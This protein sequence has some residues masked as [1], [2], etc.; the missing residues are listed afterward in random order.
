M[1][2]RAIDLGNILSVMHEVPQPAPF[3]GFY[4]LRDREAVE[5]FITAVNTQIS[6]RY[7][8]SDKD[9][10]NF[11]GCCLEGEASR[12]FRESRGCFVDY[13]YDEV[14]SDF[15]REF[16]AS[17]EDASMDSISDVEDDAEDDS[18]D[19]EDRLYRLYQIGSVLSYVG[20]F[21]SLLCKLPID[22]QNMVGPG[23]FLTGLKPKV[24]HIVKKGGSK[25]L[26]DMIRDALYAD[27]GKPVESVKRGNPASELAKSAKIQKRVADSGT[28]RFLSSQEPLPVLNA[29]NLAA[30]STSPA[31]LTSSEPA[32][33]IAPAGS[34]NHT[35]TT[36]SAVP[37]EPLLRSPATISTVPLEP[38]THSP[39]TVS[40]A[41][42]V[43]L[44]HSL[45]T[46]SS[47]AALTEF[48]TV[49][50][51]PIGQHAGPTVASLNTMSEVRIPTAPR[52]TAGAASKAPASAPKGSKLSH[53]KAPVVRVLTG[54]G[55]NAQVKATVPPTGPA[56]WSASGASGPFTK[57]TTIINSNINTQPAGGQQTFTAAA[58]AAASTPPSTSQGA[59]VPQQTASTPK[60]ADQE[61][62][63]VTT[64]SPATQLTTQ[65][66]AVAHSRTNSAAP[67]T[68]T[69]QTLA[70]RLAPIDAPSTATTTTN[71]TNSAAPMTPTQPATDYG[72]TNNSTAN[73]TTATVNNTNAAAA[74]A[75]AAVAK[76][77]SAGQS[78]SATSTHAGLVAAAAAVANAP[79]KTPAN[80]E[81][82]E[83]TG[84]V[85][86]LRSRQ[87]SV[88]PP[89]KR[90][91]RHWSPP[92]R[93]SPPPRW[94]PP[95]QTRQAPSFSERLRPRPSPTVAAGTSTRQTG[96]SLAKHLGGGNVSQDNGG[97]VDSG[98]FYCRLSENQDDTCPYHKAKVV[99]KAPARFP[100]GKGRA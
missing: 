18:L 77:P 65:T 75:A 49:A 29:P 2:K 1:V 26:P 19:F 87:A 15:R 17:S 27:S 88:S 86:V 66:P 10:I 71:T 16:I 35:P 73:N 38:L 68:A 51:S 54:N 12:W 59:T 36:V 47:A 32:A 85:P 3:Q 42:A 20:E 22:F 95:T 24:K 56:T 52:S 44:I 63:G 41:S 46:A 81:E 30:V 92:P 9:R 80:E 64:P 48:D 13:T 78:E 70:Q 94:S 69:A 28:F 79:E 39:V 8:S 74:A 6:E 97:E 58:V 67:A 25:T 99:P 55:S 76:S 43:P 14:V 40:T 84:Q 37:A 83:T 62:P 7:I 90:S 61:T 5:E 93:R 100:R 98:C 11:F 23:R 31:P 96:A 82:D 72:T 4:G 21:C 33:S 89:R 60:P 50:V 91:M 34:P 57:P 53:E 45:A